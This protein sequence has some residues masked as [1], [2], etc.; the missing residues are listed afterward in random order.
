MNGIEKVIRMLILPR[1]NYVSTIQPLLDLSE[2]G[3]SKNLRRHIA[4]GLPVCSSVHHAFQCMLYLM[5]Y[6]C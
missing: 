2:M 1:R 6:A 5:N 4:F 3:G